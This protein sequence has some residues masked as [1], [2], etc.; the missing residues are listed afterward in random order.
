MRTRTGELSVPVC[1]IAPTAHWLIVLTFLLLFALPA[2]SKADPL[3]EERMD[4][5]VSMPPDSMALGDFNADGTLD[6]VVASSTGSALDLLEND[7]TGGFPMQPRRSSSP[8]PPAALAAGDLDGDGD[9]D[10]AGAVSARNGLQIYLNN[11]NGSFP[12]SRLYAAGVMPKAVAAFDYDGDGDLD[13]ATANYSSSNVSVLVNNGVGSFSPAGAPVPVGHY[14]VA[15]QAADFD[16]DGRTD[17][18]TADY[19]NGSGTISILLNDPSGGFVVVQNPVP[20]NP[21][22]LALGDFDGDGDLDLAY[23]HRAQS[24]FSV[25][26]NDGAG[27][28]TAVSQPFDC[29]DIIGALIAADVDLDGD[30]DV[31]CAG[32]Q[33]NRLIPML[34]DGSGTFSPAEDTPAVGAFPAVVLA[35]DVNADAKPD[36]VTANMRGMTVSVMKNQAEVAELPP[37]PSELVEIV[38][39]STLKAYALTPAAVSAFPYIDRP[40]SITE[41]SDGLQGGLLVQTANDDKWIATPEHLVLRIHGKASVLVAYDK[42]AAKLPDWLDSDDW[43]LTA[44]LVKTTDACAA[45]LK[46]YLRRVSEPMDLV[47]GGNMSGGDT[48][49]RTNY[50]VLVQSPDVALAMPPVEIL[51]VASGRNYSLTRA[52]IGA[53]PY[54]DRHYRVK[55]MGASLAGGTLVQTANDDK[56]ARAAEHLKLKFNEAAAVFVCYDHRARRLPQWLLDGSWQ[57]TAERVRTSDCGASPMKIFVKDVAAGEILAFGGNHQGG[58]TRAR[59]NYFLVVKTESVV[60]LVPEPAIVEVTG[61]ISEALGTAR[62]GGTVYTDRHYRITDIGGALDGGVLVPTANNDKWDRSGDYLSLTAN[63][64]VA[65]YVCYDRRAFYLPDWLTDSAWSQA[66]ALIRTDDRKA[67]PMQVFVRSVGVGETVSLGGNHQGGD[68]RARS[69]YFVIVQQAGS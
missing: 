37:D 51:E 20:A 33:T 30:E 22:R 5:P 23:S 17:L 24:L 53:L 9:L 26:Y 2:L 61:L 3:F 54:V 39:V 8:Y 67:G 38:S 11:G 14:P 31:V 40:Y 25:I 32:A 52:E 27:G 41:L 62:T 7:G 1:G 66:D 42:R 19:G 56:W 29:G 47:L 68:T 12:Q 13:L 6:V 44:E 58:D 48:R 46:V 10:L 49:A 15:L 50:F 36:L 60:P 65:V 21:E 28:F 34:N 69:N 35:G 59:S 55:D 43:Q 4:Y 18:A 63:A 64:D 45:P 57:P 16:A